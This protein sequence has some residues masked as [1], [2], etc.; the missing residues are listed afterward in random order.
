[1]PLRLL[2]T[3]LRL[4]LALRLRLRLALRLRPRLAARFRL[5]PRACRLPVDVVKF[6]C[7]VRVRSRS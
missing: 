5:A 3:R 7:K 6:V 2:A 4:G 1:M